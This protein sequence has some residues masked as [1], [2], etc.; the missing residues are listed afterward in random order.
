MVSGKG[1]AKLVSLAE[2]LTDN[3]RF[4]LTMFCDHGV[5]HARRHLEQLGVKLR[6]SVPR[7]QIFEHLAKAHFLL[8]LSDFEGL[9]IATYEALLHGCVPLSFGQGH[10]NSIFADAAPELKLDRTAFRPKEFLDLCCKIIDE[11]RFEQ[12]SKISQEIAKNHQSF[13]R[14]LP[15]YLEERVPC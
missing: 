6:V 3:P 14:T 2:S 1:I 10:F 9:G 4:Q 7:S 11:G 12:Y 5:S 8:M 13:S 15:E